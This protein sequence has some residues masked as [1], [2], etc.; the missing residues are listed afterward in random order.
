[1]F[2]FSFFLLFLS[3][4]LSL[5]SE[6]DGSHSE[7]RVHEVSYDE[8]AANSFGFD[9]PTKHN[10]I[11]SLVERGDCTME[12]IASD[13]T[14]TR[15]ITHMRV[16]ALMERFLALKN[17]FGTPSEKKLYKDMTIEAFVT[18]LLVARP[19]VKKKRIFFFCFFSQTKQIQVFLNSSDVYM[20]R[21][22]LGR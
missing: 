7:G 9:F 8:L 5:F 6:M 19:L 18:R 4:T 21:G 20:K 1:M 13:A 12:I 3:E 22:G 10:R 15:V 14:R 16:V 17:E 11:E 2:F